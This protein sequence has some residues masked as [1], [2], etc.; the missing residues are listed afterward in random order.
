MDLLL[1]T[2]KLY[3]VGTQSPITVDPPVRDDVDLLLRSRRIEEDI[4]FY[5][6][7]I[8]SNCTKITIS[9]LDVSHAYVFPSWLPRYQ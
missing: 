9:Y 5:L 7:I 6:N 1:G 2:H 4:L 8:A 3:A